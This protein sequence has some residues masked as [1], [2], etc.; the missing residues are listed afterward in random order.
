MICKS[1][2]RSLNNDF[3]NAIFLQYKNAKFNSKKIF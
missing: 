3:I 1:C 2:G